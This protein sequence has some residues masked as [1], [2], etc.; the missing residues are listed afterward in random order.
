[1][2]SEVAFVSARAGPLPSTRSRCSCCCCCSLP[3]SIAPLPVR[4]GQ[5]PI[6]PLLECSP[7]PSRTLVGLPITTLAACR[8][9]Y[10]VPPRG[11][12]AQKTCQGCR[13]HCHFRHAPVS[14]FQALPHPSRTASRLQTWYRVSARSTRLCPPPR[15]HPAPLTLRSRSTA[16]HRSTHPGSPPPHNLRVWEFRLRHGRTCNG[17]DSGAIGTHKNERLLGRPRV[18]CTLEASPSH[19]TVCTWEQSCLATRSLARRGP[20]SHLPPGLCLRCR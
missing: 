19:R 11:S 12:L 14:L 16:R 15:S 2:R 8:S 7:T 10:C 18:L 20:Q 6:R 4:R 1:V 13:L 5:T 17:H 9:F 3:S